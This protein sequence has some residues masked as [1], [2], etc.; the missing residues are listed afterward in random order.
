MAGRK[1][2][3]P[4]CKKHFTASHLMLYVILV[5]YVCTVFAGFVFLK[6]CIDRGDSA[7]A[8]S[9]Y[10][11][12]AGLTTICGTT[13]IGFYVSKAKKENEIQMSDNKY[14]M[15]LELAKDI[16][17]EFKGKSLDEKSLQFMRTLISD[18]SIHFDDSSEATISSNT[19]SVGNIS[20]GIS[21]IVSDND[22]GLG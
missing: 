18:D 7:S 8:I 6:D 10:A 21:S 14:R 1:K 9:V 5:I 22:D 11:T 16:Y 3:N 12:L 19:F 17:R 15:R 20:G 2:T 4:Y 13:T